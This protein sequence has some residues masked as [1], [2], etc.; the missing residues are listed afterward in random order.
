MGFCA[1][2]C[3]TLAFKAQDRTLGKSSLLIFGA[4]VVKVLLFDL[5]NA[6]PLVRIGSLIVLAVTL[7]VGGWM[8]KRVDALEEGSA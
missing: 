2:A 6:A 4:S 8:C 7:Y 1:L 3:L 5:D